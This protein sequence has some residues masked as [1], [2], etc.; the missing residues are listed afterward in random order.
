VEGRRLGPARGGEHEHVFRR[1]EPEADHTPREVQR[2]PPPPC[3]QI[4]LLDSAVRS[5]SAPPGPSA[6]GRGLASARTASERAG[7]TAEGADGD[8]LPA[9]RALE[10]RHQRRQRVATG[11]S[12][13]GAAGRPRA[14]GGRPL[15]CRLA[16]PDAASS[17]PRH[18]PAVG[19]NAHSRPQHS[20][21]P[22]LRE[23]GQPP[24][25]Q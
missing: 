2:Q 17:S 13:P 1:A 22:P 12:P 20:T 9:A 4:C 16:L 24:D 11:S 3:P 18:Y 15:S 5:K 23:R 19:P 10:L 21:G 25:S 8:L 7:I 6:L 14:G